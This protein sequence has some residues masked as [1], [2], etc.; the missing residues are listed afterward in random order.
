M[1]RKQVKDDIAKMNY[2]GEAEL[3]DYR[4]HIAKAYDTL[5]INAGI[6]RL[7]LKNEERDERDES[8]TSC[9]FNHKQ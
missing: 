6:E 5:K 8:N 1:E 4:A 9:F 3:L 7:D 2:E